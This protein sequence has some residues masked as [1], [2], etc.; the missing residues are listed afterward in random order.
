LHG[1][2]FHTEG[3]H[4]DPAKARFGNLG[5]MICGLANDE[6][7]LEFFEGLKISRN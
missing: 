3:A 6:L 4:Q 7:Q 2:G 1:W 5:Y